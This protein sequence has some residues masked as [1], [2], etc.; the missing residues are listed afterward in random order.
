MQIVKLYGDRTGTVHVLND[1]TL[2]IS[3]VDGILPVSTN[4]YPQGT[5]V[6]PSSVTMDGSTLKFIS[7]GT[8]VGL[9]DLTF[10]DSAK[11]EM[12]GGPYNLNSLFIGDFCT[13][14][15]VCLYL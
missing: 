2:D 6:L 5:A 15:L 12:C 11:L 13:G 4:V 10:L 7:C 14:V 1:T 3:Q 9:T 8:L